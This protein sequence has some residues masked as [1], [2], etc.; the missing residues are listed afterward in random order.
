MVS[1]FQGDARLLCKNT[2]IQA[3]WLIFLLGVREA[4]ELDSFFSGNRLWWEYR[5]GYSLW[6]FLRKSI[7]L[8]LFRHLL[9]R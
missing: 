6:V 2:I 9:G 4:V 8:S 1:V 3:H 5:L 7:I